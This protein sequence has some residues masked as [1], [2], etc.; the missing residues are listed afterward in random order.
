MEPIVSIIVPIYKAEL[1]LAQCIESIR[2]QTVKEIEIILIDDG[3][4]DG[5]P[6]MCD[7]FAAGD[8]RIRVFHQE[9]AGVSAARN[10]GMEMAAGEWLMFV[11]PDD[12]LEPN[13]VEVLYGQAKSSGCDIVYASYYRDYPDEQ[14]QFDMDSSQVG[15]YVVEQDFE[16]LMEGFIRSE[17]LKVNMAPPWGK[18][19]RKSMIDAHAECRFP[20]GMKQGEDSIFNLYALRHAGSV[21][22]LDIPVYHYRMRPDSASIALF[23]DQLERYRRMIEEIHIYMEK[24]QMLDHFLPYYYFVCIQK[25]FFLAIQYGKNIRGVQDFRRAAFHLKTFCGEEKITEVIMHAEL[26]SVSGK[27][28]LWLLRHHLYGCVMLLSYARSKLCPK[29]W[30]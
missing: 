3:S 12:W 26:E 6:E 7:R 1:Y 19:Y 30:P 25:V 13:A 18:I 10:R 11:D 14:I 9:N 4:P 17:K 28:V 27:G 5:S 24:Y 20:D 16:I 8:E 22:I 29:A 21:Y 2:N 15:K 23:S